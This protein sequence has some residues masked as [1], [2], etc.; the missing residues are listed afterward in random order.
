MNFILRFQAAIK[1]ALHN[2]SNESFSLFLSTF[3][4]FIFIST[5]RW[6]PSLG[7]SSANGSNEGQ[8]QSFGDSHHCVINGIE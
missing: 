6:P 1:A 4:S 8:L 5:G 2:S 3:F 7:I